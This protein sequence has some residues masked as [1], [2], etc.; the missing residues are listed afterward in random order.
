MRILGEPELLRLD[1][2]ERDRE[3]RDD[4]E[5]LLEEELE[6]DLERDLRGEASEALPARFRNCRSPCAA[7]SNSTDSLSAP[8]SGSS[9]SLF[10]CSSSK[11]LKKYFA[12]SSSGPGLAHASV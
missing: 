2:R 9:E 10:T 5:D 1:E 4:L 3:E 7:P 12:S 8:D 11:P 6:R